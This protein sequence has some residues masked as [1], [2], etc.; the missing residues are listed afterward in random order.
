VTFAPD[1]SIATLSAVTATVP[2]SSLPPAKTTGF[3]SFLRLLTLLGEYKGRVAISWS[4][5][6]VVTIVYLSVP[7]FIGEAITALKDGDYDRAN[8]QIKW[9][10]AAAVFRAILWFFRRAVAGTISLGLEQHLRDRLFSHLAGMSFRFFDRQSTGQLL[11]R[12]TV[13]VTSVRF[14]L[15]YGL[16]Y[17]FTHIMQLVGVSILLWLISPTLARTAY[18]MIPIIFFISSRYSRRSHA[19]MKDIQ[20]R[21][22]DVTAAAEENIIGGRI[23]RAFGQEHAETEKFRVLTDRIVEKEYEAARIAARYRPFYSFV[24]NLVLAAI[25]MQAVVLY[26]HG[27]LE[28]GDFYKVYFYLLLLVGPIRIIGNLVSRA[29]R[30]TASGERLFEILDADDRLPVL[31][32]PTPIPERGMGEVRFEGVAFEYEGSDLVLDHVDLVIPA[33]KTVALLGPTG[34]GKTTLASLVPRLYDPTEGTVLLDGVDLRDFDLQEL[35]RQVGVVDQ[36]PYL[37]SATVAE[38]IAFGRPDATLDDIRDAARAAQALE[39]VEHLPKGFDTMIGERGLTLSG[40]QRQ[41]LAIA[42]ALLTN[43]RVLILD[44]ATASVDARVE[45]HIT[46]ALAGATADRTTILIAHRPSTIALADMIVIMDAGHIADMGTHDELI[47]RNELYRQIHEQRAIHT[48]REFLID[49]SLEGEG[50]PA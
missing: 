15:G 34:C 7:N 10:I 22:A 49:P 8:N 48:R 30:A 19:V 46:T 31:E 1:T 28:L 6:F 25:M 13:D 9:L 39:F 11:S 41:R 4:L 21:E 40:G 3:R 36:E 29:Q 2:A 32:N 23:V 5:A 47:T 50:S 26:T 42:R 35:R 43:P 38:N 18:V 14:F 12:V 45:Q 17:F 20:Q 16:I 33:G 37:F 24:P 44:D 27:T